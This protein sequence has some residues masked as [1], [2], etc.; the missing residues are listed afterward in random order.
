MFNASKEICIFRRT[1]HVVTLMAYPAQSPN[2]KRPAPN[3]AGPEW[4]S[5][6]AALQGVELTK[7]VQASINKP[8][9]VSCFQILNPGKVQQLMIRIM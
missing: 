2:L 9:R 8:D 5:Y 3:A 6:I 1:V 4:I 7:D